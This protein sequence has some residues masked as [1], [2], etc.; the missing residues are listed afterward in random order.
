MATGTAEYIPAEIKRSL[1]KGYETEYHLL[2]FGPKA[3]SDYLRKEEHEIE[4]IKERLLRSDQGWKVEAVRTTGGITGQEGNNAV[5]H[6]IDMNFGMH[7]A[8]RNLVPTR[9]DRAVRFP[10]A[11]TL[12]DLNRVIASPGE[13][14]PGESRYGLEHNMGIYTNLPSIGR[15]EPWERIQEAKTPYFIRGISLH[16]FYYYLQRGGKRFIAGED[17]TRMI[18]G[19]HLEDSRENLQDKLAEV[20]RSLRKLLEQE[21]GHRALLQVVGSRPDPFK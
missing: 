7:T 21:T 6:F 5:G 11:T 2:G 12:L 3:W 9:T 19:I 4:A 18:V 16:P 15:F 8:D 10:R 13:L 17:V 14:W 20:E 1:K